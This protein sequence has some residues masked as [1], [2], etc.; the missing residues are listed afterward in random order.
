LGFLIVVLARFIGAVGRIDGLC[1][2]PA[3]EAAGKKGI[4]PQSGAK[5]KDFG[6]DLVKKLERVFS[7]P[8]LRTKTVPN[9]EKCYP[10][11][12]FGTCIGTSGMVSICV[13]NLG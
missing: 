13:F 7:P 5:F 9:E 12:H 2:F 3:A 6:T 11:H 4:L 10:A 1:D 8:K